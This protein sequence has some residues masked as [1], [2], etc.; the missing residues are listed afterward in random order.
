MDQ[1]K[2]PFLIAYDYGMGG[3]WGVMYARSADEIAAIY[4][5]LFVVE[6]RPHWMDTEELKH[7]EETSYD[8]DGAPRGLLNVLLEDRD[9]K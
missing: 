7:L 2:R 6:E 9:H 5:E 1:I 8:I 3:L 4:P